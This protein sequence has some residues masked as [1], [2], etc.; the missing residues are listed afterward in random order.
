MI[1][2]EMDYRDHPEN[3]KGWDAVLYDAKDYWKT[4]HE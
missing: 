3:H 4:A 2:L 1:K